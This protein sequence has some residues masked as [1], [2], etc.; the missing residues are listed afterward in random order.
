MFGGVHLAKG[1]SGTL[2][3]GGITVV[4][5]TPCA[6]PLFGATLAAALTAP[7]SVGVLAFASFGVGVALPMCAALS[8]PGV[9][10]RLPRAGAWT[11]VLKHLV[12]FS[13][14]GV[15]AWTIWLLSVEAGPPGVGGL[16][17]CG[18]AFAFA[19]WM[20]SRA[21][22]VRR[23]VWRFARLA[24]SLALLGIAIRQLHGIEPFEATPITRTERQLAYTD[25]RRDSLLT[26]GRTVLVDFTAAWCLTCQV[27]E[28]LVLGTPTV[29]QLFTDRRV[30]VLRADLTTRDSA[31]W[32]ALNAVGRQS[33]PT[34]A[35]FTPGATRSAPTLLPELLTTAVVRS[36]LDA[37]AS[38]VTASIQSRN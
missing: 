18:L 22:A 37:T 28:R 10:A 33:L 27:N 3:L 9:A 8:I 1:L 34:Y 14:F 5:G 32:A 35:L 4:A 13:L 24:G 19:G 36:A 21:I 20:A 25:A 38:R 31:T 30:T 2:L 15:A 26:A 6:A 16:L 11:E 23:R 7:I 12:G 29:R 17:T